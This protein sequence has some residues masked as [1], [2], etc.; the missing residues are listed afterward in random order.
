MPGGFFSLREIAYCFCLTAH[1][2]VCGKMVRRYYR[3]MTATAV[4]AGN[5]IYRPSTGQ[6]TPAHHSYQREKSY[7]C[8]KQT[9]GYDCF[10]LFPFSPTVRVAEILI[11][12]KRVYK[13]RSA[14]LQDTFPSIWWEQVVGRQDSRPNAQRLRQYKTCLR[15]L[16]N[17]ANP[18][19][20]IKL[21][22]FCLLMLQSLVT[23]DDQVATCR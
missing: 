22:F 12:Y 1:C 13:G 11:I 14:G 8:F 21:V 7:F 5:Q 15:Q 18:V 23:T 4:V 20:K 16:R 9:I 17:T 10:D 3:L 2:A 6:Y 19:S